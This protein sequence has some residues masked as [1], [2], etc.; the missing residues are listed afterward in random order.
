MNILAM[1]LVEMIEGAQDG[2]AAIRY[3][4]AQRSLGGSTEDKTSAN[5]DASQAKPP[6]EPTPETQAEPAPET[7]TKPKTQPES[8]S[9]ASDDSSAS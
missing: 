1:V 7:K 6:A 4:S 3:L 9:D 5:A 2:F 8:D